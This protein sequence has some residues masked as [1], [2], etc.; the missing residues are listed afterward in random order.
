MVEE[1]LTARGIEFTDET[2]RCRATT[3]GLAIARRIRSTALAH[4]DK[5]HRDEGAVTIN[6]R[7]H[8]LARVVDAHGAVLDV[9]VQSHRDQAEAKRLLRTRLK[10]HGRP[11]VIVTDTLRRDAAANHEFGLKVAHRQHNGLNNRAGHSHPPTRGRE[12]GMRRV[13][14]PRH[15]Q[16]LASI[17]GPMANLFMG[18][19]A[20]PKRDVNA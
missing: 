5:W 14:S 11:R 15:L 8:G 17:H 3:F 6:G 18:C 20:P 13:T 9:L 1:R 12:K 10:R 19:R 2:V 7:S 16:R 4:G